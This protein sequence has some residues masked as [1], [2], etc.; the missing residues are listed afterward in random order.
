[1]AQGTFRSGGDVLRLDRGVSSQGSIFIQTHRALHLR[2]VQV[3]V[4]KSYL[5]KTVYI[6]FKKGRRCLRV[7]ASGLRSKDRQR[8]RKEPR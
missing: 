1:M 6:F 4:Y 8:G 7:K 3:T 5:D 2:A